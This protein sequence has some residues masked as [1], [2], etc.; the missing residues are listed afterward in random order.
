MLIKAD[1]SKGLPYALHS[2]RLHSVV[3]KE[4]NK[5]SNELLEL[6]AVNRTGP[7]HTFR[8][9]SKYLGITENGDLMF[10]VRYCISTHALLVTTF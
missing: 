8:R 4:I 2:R 3:W 10:E 6:F 9:R 1:N 5:S 7:R